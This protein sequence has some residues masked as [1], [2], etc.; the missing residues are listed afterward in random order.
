MS[1]PRSSS[2]IRAKSNCQFYAWA[3]FSSHHQTVNKGKLQSSYT[4]HPQPRSLEAGEL[5]SCKHGR[6]P[7]LA[8]QLWSSPPPLL[9]SALSSTEAAALLRVRPLNC[10]SDRSRVSRF[11]CYSVSP[12]RSFSPF[13]N[14]RENFDG[15][16]ACIVALSSAPQYTTLIGWYAEKMREKIQ[17]ATIYTRKKKILPPT[18]SCHHHQPYI[19]RSGHFVK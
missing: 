15:L 1:D 13:Y 16:V 5:R 19:P 18:R 8:L 11:T 12:L 4:K 2:T 9:S 10:H 17:Y 6:F 3:T 7:P 14:E